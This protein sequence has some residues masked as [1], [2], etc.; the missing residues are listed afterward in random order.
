VRLSLSITKLCTASAGLAAA[1]LAAC[2]GN[3]PS[4]PAVLYTLSIRSGDAQSGPAGSLLEEP[5]QVTVV[6][7]D[8]TPAKGVAVRFRL[9]GSRA[10]QLTDTLALT[11]SDGI[12]RTLLRLGNEK[13]TSVVTAAVPGQDDR[14]VTF[15]AVATAGATLT[16]VDPAR[17]APGDTVTV[18]GAR[19]NVSAAGNTVFFGGSRGR[20]VVTSG[21]SLL[22]AVVPPCL[23]SG[24]VQ[25]QV[26]IGSA[27]TNAVAATVQGVGA[28]VRLAAYEAVTVS[29]TEAGSC[30]VLAPGTRYI[31]IPQSA[32]VGEAAPA[33]RVYALGLDTAITDPN[34]PRN[35][36]A[37]AAVDVAPG[38]VDGR[39]RLERFLRAEERRVARELAATGAY[40]AGA[41][42]LSRSGL[43]AQGV[44]PPDPPPLGSVREFSVLSNIEERSFTRASARLRYAG[45]NILIYEDV[46]SPEP[47][48]DDLVRRTGA[49][50]DQ[51]LY[52][53]DVSTFGAE[54]DV[55]G[56]GRVIVLLTPVVNALYSAQRCASEG[57]S[58]GFFYNIDLGRTDRN[59][60]RAEIFYLFVPDSRGTRSC[61][62]TLDEVTSLLPPT[63]LHEFQHM[64][65]Y[66]QHVLAR[67]GSEEDV[68]LNEGLSQMAEELGA[69][70]YDQRFPAPGGRTNAGQ[71]FPDS[72]APFLRQNLV[73]AALYLASTSSASVTTFADLGTLEERGA[74]WLFVRWLMAQ[75]GDGILARLVQTSR[76]SRRNVE[77]VTGETFPG[78][79]GDFGVALYADSIV[80]VPRSRIP[81][82]Y[83][84]AG[85]S[86]RELLARA[87]N[88]LRYPLTVRTAPSVVSSAQGVLSQ[89]T[90]DY[91]DVT[92]SRPGGVAVRF[93]PLGGG[94]F[95][96]NAEAQIGVLR[97]TP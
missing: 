75:K 65:S 5:L 66:N 55:D 30:L 10:G 14:G 29:G 34:A 42:R 13:D 38:H 1:A 53:I 6:D 90:L 97:L 33:Q 59:S 27:Q 62:H 77:D 48:T 69:R 84:F 39:A 16:S 31:L 74:A 78:L 7:P 92:V 94:A 71:L 4:E 40:P 73:N 85:Y 63:F 36:G 9:G 64:I 18:R 57:Y 67:R 52:T 26:Q 80:G 86:L 43:N 70:H 20:V 50:F 81:A 95:P 11:G 60:N 23:A 47:L 96:S 8:N 56:N 93:G 54:S 49:L 89:G 12:A 82:R 61:A 45:Q 83:R 87:G 79:F 88:R 68:W 24:A 58:P 25:V 3:E 19:F 2:R 28:P 35:A 72:A 22:R 17:F 37:L 41:P 15:R 91:Y 21:D 76:T 32:S 44:I 46:A 51:T